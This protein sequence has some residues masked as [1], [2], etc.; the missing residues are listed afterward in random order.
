MPPVTEIISHGQIGAKNAG[1]NVV[2][3]DVFRAVPTA[4]AILEQKPSI[5]YMTSDENNVCSSKPDFVRI[6]K[7]FMGSNVNYDAPNSPTRVS[8]FD[9]HEQSVIHRTAGCGGCLDGL[10]DQKNVLLCSISNVVAT[11]FFMDKLGGK[12]DIIAAGHQGN[13]PVEEDNL[14]ANA[15][16]SEDPIGH[17]ETYVHQLRNTASSLRFSIDSDEYPLTDVDICLSTE[18]VSTVILAMKIGNLW[19]LEV[20][21]K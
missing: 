3:I 16:I 7:P 15:L 11:R 18:Q 1:R 2:I 17:I 9:L 21:N 8:E 10:V 6:G 4:I 12:W 20:H 14:C 13:T 5:Y 19:K